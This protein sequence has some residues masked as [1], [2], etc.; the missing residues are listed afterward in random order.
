MSLAT[1]IEASFQ[2]FMSK[3]KVRIVGAGF[4]SVKN[5]QRFVDK[6]MAKWCGEATIEMDESHPEIRRQNEHALNIPV[7]FGPPHLRSSVTGD[8]R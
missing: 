4:T 8:L 2:S 1:P 3:I 7:A 6:G 5:A